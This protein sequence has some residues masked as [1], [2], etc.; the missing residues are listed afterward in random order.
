MS[1]DLY[2]FDRDDPRDDEE[3]IGELIQDDS[4][5]AAPL[6]PRLAVFVAELERRYPGLDVDSDNSPWASWP[7]S[8]SVADGTGVALNIV[9]SQSEAVST[10]VRALAHQQ[11]L[12][13]YDPQAS[14]IISPTPQPS[15]PRVPSA[16][17]RWWNRR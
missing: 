10:A 7:L 8:D 17:K 3:A 15:T 6:T 13:V 5:W 1:F 4:R 16:R 14:E 11:T 2:V 9:W 12:T